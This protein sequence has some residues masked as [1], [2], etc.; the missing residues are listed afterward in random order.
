[1]IYYL[2]CTGNTYW[3]AKQLSEATNERMI[4][5]A[6]AIN[7]KCICHLRD[8]ERLGFCLPVHGWRVQPIVEQF[9]N[10]L[11]IHCP[12]KSIIGKKFL[13][14]L[15]IK[16]PIISKNLFII[17]WYAPLIFIFFNVTFY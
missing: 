8:G 16:F 4:S 10:K 6:D 1:M 17:Y 3:A 11:E 13:P 9:I 7:D 2:S 14:I 12:I 15:I 5:I